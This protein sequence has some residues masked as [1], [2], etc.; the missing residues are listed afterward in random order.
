MAD[1]LHPLPVLE[2]L[3][4]VRG[5]GHAADGFDIAAGHGL[6]VGDDRQC[7][8]HRA[9]VPRRLFRRQPVE[10]GLHGGPALEAPAARDLHEFDLAAGP[11][12]L[13]LVEQLAHGVGRQRR[14]E[15]LRQLRHR[16]GF[17]RDQQCGFE[18]ALDFRELVGR[19]RVG[20]RRRA[21][22][23]RRSFVRR[24][25][26]GRLGLAVAR[27]WVR[28]VRPARCSPAAP[29]RVRASPGMS[30]RGARCPRARRRAR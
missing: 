24:Q 27:R 14:V 30:R 21:G 17:A 29:A 9:R 19:E 7:F 18:D 3:D 16:H 23:D 1:G 22:C 13:Q 10:I 5:H 2:R 4:D 20:A 11:L 28:R 15:E 8:H 26:K 25:G 6:L 12:A